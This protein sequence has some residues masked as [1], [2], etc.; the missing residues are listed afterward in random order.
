MGMDE[1]GGG[2]LGLLV[3]VHLVVSCDTGASE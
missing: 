3:E 2:F 1:V